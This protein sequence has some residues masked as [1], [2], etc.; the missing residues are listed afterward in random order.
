MYPYHGFNF[1]SKQQSRFFSGILESILVSGIINSFPE[2]SSS[3]KYF[4]TTFL[5]TII[6]VIYSTIFLF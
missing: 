1:K 6:I 2:L 3:K 4:L 5:I